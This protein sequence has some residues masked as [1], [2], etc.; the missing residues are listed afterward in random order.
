MKLIISFL[1]I[2]YL[3]IANLPSPKDLMLQW[4]G[5]LESFESRG[6]AFKSVTTLSVGIFLDTNFGE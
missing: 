3:I 4:K 1:C 6:H 2:D 5:P